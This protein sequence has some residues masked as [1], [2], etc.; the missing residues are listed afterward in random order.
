[1]R[2]GLQEGILVRLWLDALANYAKGVVICTAATAPFPARSPLGGCCAGGAPPTRLH[3][4]GGKGVRAAS[5]ASAAS[6]SCRAAAAHRA[7][8]LLGFPPRRESPL[9]FAFRS[10]AGARRST[11]I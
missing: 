11:A 7:L 1:M 5:F 9:V 2:Y 10:N 3:R 4:E 8:D 6:G